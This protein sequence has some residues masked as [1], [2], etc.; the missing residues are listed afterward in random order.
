L[1]NLPVRFANRRRLSKLQRV[2]D[3]YATVN[4]EAHDFSV[5]HYYISRDAEEDQLS[6]L[7]FTL[8]E[9]LDLHA[10]AVQ[11][12]EHASH[13]SELHYVARR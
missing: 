6:E 8:I 5:L 11:V 2:E 10:R 4:D 9:C 7:G 13:C 1:R 12:G 3:G